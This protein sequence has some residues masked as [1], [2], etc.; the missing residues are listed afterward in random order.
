MLDYLLV[1]VLSAKIS[2]KPSKLLSKGLKKAVHLNQCK[3]KLGM[4]MRQIRV[5][6]FSKSNCLGVNRLVF[7]F[8]QT[9]IM[10]QKGIVPLGIIYQEVLLINITLSSMQIIIIIIIITTNQ[11]ILL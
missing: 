6:I 5:D 8:I 2:Q 11:L 4:K 9:M 3:R 7:W 10:L 1:V